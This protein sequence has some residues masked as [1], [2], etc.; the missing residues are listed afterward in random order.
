MTETAKNPS[1]FSISANAA[2]H[3]AKVRAD[4][5]KPDLIFRL[6]VSGGGCSGFKYIYEFDSEMHDGDKTFEKDGVTVVTD[7]MSLN[8]LQG[9]ELDFQNDLMGSRF[10]VNNP[11]A[12]SSCGCGTSFSMAFDQAPIDTQE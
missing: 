12:S 9:A 4:K 2:A 7:D 5:N 8:F 10:A 6:T 11:N 1:N 3:I